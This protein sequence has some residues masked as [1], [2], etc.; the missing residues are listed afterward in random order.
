MQTNSQHVVFIDY[1]RIV[2]CF[3]VMLVHASENFY[4]LVSTSGLAIPCI[5]ALTYLCCLVTTKLLSLLPGSK[6]FVGC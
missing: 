5:A 1:I 3:L 2:S 4:G 6:W